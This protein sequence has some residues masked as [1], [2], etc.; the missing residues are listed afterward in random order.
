MRLRGRG[1]HW[2]PR[3]VDR[4][5]RVKVTVAGAE[6]LGSSNYVGGQDHVF[7]HD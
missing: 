6:A 2:D 4:A 3:R 1:K 5:Q 7:D